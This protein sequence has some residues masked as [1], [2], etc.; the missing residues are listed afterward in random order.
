MID[1]GG[2]PDSRPPKYE[3]EGI[4]LILAE[5]GDKPGHTFDVSKAL[6][7]GHVGVSVP[8]ANEASD[9][10]AMLEPAFVL[11]NR[12][13]NPADKVARIMRAVRRRS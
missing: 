4:P 8:E 2:R 9:A 10:P 7:R 1:A 3:H 11:G 5:V 6:L 12:T 13:L